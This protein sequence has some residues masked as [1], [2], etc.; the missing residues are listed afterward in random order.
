MSK[1]DRLTLAFD[2]GHAE[3]PTGSVTVLR[4][5]PKAI[6]SQF[7][8]CQVWQGFKPTADALTAQGLKLVE[9]L[10]FATDHV[11]VELTRSKAENLALV[12][13]GYGLLNDA[14]TLIIDGSKTDGIESILKSVRKHLNITNV[15]SKSH[16]KV[17]QI[18]HQGT[19]PAHMQAWTD[20]LTP[21]KNANGWT[22]HAGMFSHNAIDAGS[23]LLAG[24]L[25]G[26]LSGKVA[27]LGAGWGYLSHTALAENPNIT[28]LDL[29]EAEA[30]A[31]S[32]ARLNVTDP[33]A[34]FHWQDATS[35]PVDGSYKCVI[36]NPPFHVSRKADPDLG[37][38]FIRAAFN[39][40][41]PNGQLIMVAN[42]Q[43]A[44]EATLTEVFGAWDI[45]EETPTYKVMSAKRPK[46][47]SKSRT[48]SR[49]A[50]S[51]R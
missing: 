42:R 48:M 34:G 9:D 25:N 47:G 22:T 6:Y 19:A 15:F 40:L 27:D 5:T 35:M 4:A 28:S 21:V 23:A 36:M 38:H 37:R 29:F 26:T 14:G 50:R 43:L 39:M 44:Y 12:A 1:S 17:I 7:A 32:C 16:G 11:I 33:R 24:H 45:V 31:L 18:D 30:S 46:A 3:L 20:A 10:P 51:H 41:H 8:D 13:R 2:A 49:P